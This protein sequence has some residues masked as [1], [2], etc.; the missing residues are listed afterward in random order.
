MLFSRAIN[1]ATNTLS[2]D[3]FEPKKVKK[4]AAKKSQWIEISSQIEFL[5]I[6]MHLQHNK[7]VMKQSYLRNEYA[8]KKMAQVFLSPT[9]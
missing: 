2:I 1:G 4:T 9:V 3:P 6:H 7:V 5:I 8:L